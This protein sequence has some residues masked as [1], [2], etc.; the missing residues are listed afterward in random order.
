VR[1]GSIATAVKR[2]RVAG[3][4]GLRWLPS[5]LVV[6]TAIC[7]VV[8]F[9]PVMPGANLD[10]S[11]RMGMNQAVAQGLAIGRDIIFTFG[12]YASIY[13][14]TYHPATDAMMLWGS[15]LFAVCL[16]IAAALTFRKGRWSVQLGLVAILHLMFVEDPLLFYYP[17]LV[18]IH[19]IRGFCIGDDGEQEGAK[20][21]AVLL[22]LLTPFGLLPLVK[23]TAGVLCAVVVAVVVVLLAALRRAKL[24]ALV[25]AAPLLSTVVFWVAAG[26]SLGALPGYFTSMLPIVSGYTQAMETQGGGPQMLAYI[27]V[28]LL[29]LAVIVAK[30]RVPP[31]PKAALVAVVAAA[32][33]L[34]FKGGFVRHDAH[35]VIAGTFLVLTGLLIAAIYPF[36]QADVALFL[37]LCVWW[38]IDA[39]YLKTS[40]SSFLTRIGS[41]YASAWN[42]VRLRVMDKD[43]LPR[44]FDAALAKVRAEAGFPTLPGSSDIYSYDQS[45][46]IASGNQWNPRPVF[47]S[48]SAYTPS[49][50][51]ANK[52]HLLG[53]HAPDNLIFNVQ[54]ID[55]RLPAL[56]DGA[57]WP[58]IL[59]NY[60]PTRFENDFLFLH[61]RSNTPDVAEQPVATGR[62]ALGQDVPVP[63]GGPMF[64]RVDLRPTALGAMAGLLYKPT[65]L[66]ITLTLDSGGT[67]TY[68]MV[69]GMARTGFL[70]SPL[71]ENSPE[72]GFLYAGAEYIR[73]KTVRSF[74]IA[75]VSGNSLWQSRF[76]VEFTPVSFPGAPQTAR[77]LNL[78]RPTPLGSR[79]IVR[80]EHCDG[81]IDTVNGATPAPASFVAQRLLSVAG[82]LAVSTQR[83]MVAETTHLVA[84]AAD[85]TTWLMPTRRISRPDVGAY[86][87]KPQLDATGYATTVD[88]AALQGRYTLGIAYEANGTINLCPQFAIPGRFGGP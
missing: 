85:G 76:D 15:L 20:R 27:G 79:K 7:V 53:S 58:V 45:Y 3:S 88:V 2:A 24:A 9:S 80:A 6:L 39:T 51:E 38:S 78:D 11:W 72:L 84:T 19:A 32:L 18:G 46:L 68:R 75:P 44:E 28:A 64:V 25:L 30:E 65:Q 8:P 41:N 48:Y 82:W 62:Y 73:H 42:G 77:L 34:A 22:L 5:A 35:A 10:P 63:A 70:I 61:R 87:G 29:L 67:R 31:A 71:I 50:L 47:Q 74:A 40:T 54:P 83:G 56:E 57:S 17:L 55:D 26:Q 37:C 23:G 60:A 49:L 86:F 66:Q 33:F 36:A 12:P 14:G 43:R 1:R 59:R 4:T 52:A 69:A 16:G 81:T 21:V 13:T